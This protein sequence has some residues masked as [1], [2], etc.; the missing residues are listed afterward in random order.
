MGCSIC[1]SPHRESILAGLKTG[2]S[3][4]K[5]A[6]Q[7]GVSR[8]SLGRHS[9]KCLQLR[10][11]PNA[12]QKTMAAVKRAAYNEDLDTALEQTERLRQAAE[13]C[14]D[15]KS[16]LIAQRHCNRL[17][18]LKGR[19]LPREEKVIDT[20]VAESWNARI[21]REGF[22][23]AKV[24]NHPDYQFLTSPPEELAKANF[25]FEIIF[26]ERR[27]RELRGSI[28]EEISNSAPSEPVARQPEGEVPPQVTEE[29]RQ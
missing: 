12:E 4:R 16:A 24:C 7:F 9:L 28:W 6:A 10:R 2:T 13:E 14:G 26:V 15:V 1:Q 18:A 5:L 27:P 29:V 20:N 8:G 22:V 17:L 3:L 25:V 21:A 23:F 19:T 11:S